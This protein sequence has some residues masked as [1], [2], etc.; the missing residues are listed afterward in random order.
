[1]KT[2]LAL[3]LAVCCSLVLSSFTRPPKPHLI[4]GNWQLL[5]KQRYNLLFTKDSKAYSLERIALS[6]DAISS[7]IALLQKNK[8]DELVTDYG[9]RVFEPFDDFQTPVLLFKDLCN[10]KTRL[11]F[12]ILELSKGYL[13]LKFEP[14]HS[15][16]DVK[17]SEPVLT[18]ERTA[19][20]SE[21][22]PDSKSSD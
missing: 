6:S 2:S 1:M 21:N 22:M 5:E 17:I 8:K 15:S 10:K 9:Y 4:V 12:S 20:P 14:A 16:S 7:S 3:V 13:K 11:V 19:G 18:F